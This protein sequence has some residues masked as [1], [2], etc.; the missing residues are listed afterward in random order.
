M[1]ASS[2]RPAV[3]SRAGRAGWNAAVDYC[4]NNWL[5]DRSA[6]SKHE[7]MHAIINNP[8]HASLMLEDLKAKGAGKETTMYEE[9]KPLKSLK[10]ARQYI[11]NYRSAL[12]RSEQELGRTRLRLEEAQRNLEVARGRLNVAAKLAESLRAVAE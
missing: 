8:F 1:S 3:S 12:T 4:T 9:D 6:L 11:E 10:Q 5:R 7:L 2:K